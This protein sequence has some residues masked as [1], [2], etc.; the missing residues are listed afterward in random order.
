[1]PRRTTLMAMLPS[2]VR[3]GELRAMGA[4]LGAVARST[5]TTSLSDFTR[6]CGEADHPFQRLLMVVWA[7]RRRIEPGHGW[8]ALVA[9]LSTG[10]TGG[11]WVRSLVQEAFAMYAVIRRRAASSQP[12][13]R[14]SAD[15]AHYLPRAVSRLLTSTGMGALAP[16]RPATLAEQAVSRMAALWDSMAGVSCIMWLDNFY[17]GRHMPNPAVRDPS[18]NSSVMSVL[19]VTQLP[20]PARLPSVAQWDGQ[21]QAVS[22]YV[23]ALATGYG[24]RSR[25]LAAAAPSACRT[26]SGCPWT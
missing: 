21:R 19:H 8:D 1:M 18:L 2:V 5:T 25:T 22:R 12:R 10:S 6:L 24:R 4:Q 15:G 14:L 20:P 23:P 26:P 17:R 13:P 11:R 16:P 7:M 9:A 3:A